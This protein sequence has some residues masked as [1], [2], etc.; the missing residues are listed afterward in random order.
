[1]TGERRGRT[2]SYILREAVWLFSL[3][4]KAFQRRI[5]SWS[6]DYSEPLYCFLRFWWVFFLQS[7]LANEVE[8]L[9]STEEARRHLADL[10][11]DRKIL[12]QELLQLK[13]KKEAGE[14]PP[15]KLRVRV[16]NAVFPVPHLWLFS[17]YCH[18]LLLTPIWPFPSEGRDGDGSLSGKRGWCCYCPL[19]CWGTELL[20]NRVAEVTC[21]LMQCIWQ[22]WAVP[23]PYQRLYA[24]GKEQ[25]NLGYREILGGFYS[26]MAPLC[27]NVCKWKPSLVCVS[28]PI[29][30]F[31][32]LL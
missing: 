2:W 14:N 22:M 16:E 26:S 11:E 1:M 32:P 21:Y 24:F 10:L 3:S 30:H 13:E 8:V 29:A 12:A 20:G 7:W 28:S 17:K 23:I 19:A 15:L 4:V 18:L 9:V 25:W 6:W 27:W 31:C 5:Q